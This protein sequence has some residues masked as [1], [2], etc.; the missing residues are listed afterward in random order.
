MSEVLT[1]EEIKERVKKAT[2]K[3]KPRVLPDNV[4]RF[5]DLCIEMSKLYE[6]KN[7]D[8]GD[9]F[10]Q[11]F[12]KLGMIS[13]ITRISDKY[14]RLVSLGT[15]SNPMMVKDESLRDTLIDLSS[16][17]L[18]TVAELDKIKEKKNVKN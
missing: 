10:S 1:K 4:K 11:T 18:M 15:N 7:N 13:A 12:Q 2:E 17:S 6:R 9:S 16:Y 5:K 8:Y 14:N 3:K